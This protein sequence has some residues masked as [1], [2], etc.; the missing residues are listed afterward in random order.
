M[1]KNPPPTGLRL[2]ACMASGMVLV[3][4][5]PPA[6]LHWLHW[7][8]FLPMFWAMQPGQLRKN[9]VLAYLG[10]VAG[11]FVIFWWLIETV[12][13]FSS[14]PWALGLLVLILHSVGFSVS[15]AAIGSARWLRKRLGA[16][17]I[18]ALPVLVVAAERVCP[19]LFPWYHGVVHFKS[20]WVFQLASVTGVMG[21]SWVVVLVN[22]ALAELMYRRQ[23]GRS[24]PW[25]ALGLVTAVVLGV[26]GFGAWRTAAIEAEL[27]QAKTLRV[28]ILQQ[29]VTME[30]RLVQRPIEALASWIRL[31]RKVEDDQPDLVI[32]PEGSVNFN[33]NS[34]TEAKALGGRSPRV[35]FED[36]TR[37]ANFDFMIGGGT[38][39]RNPDAFKGYTAHNSLYVY[40][41]SGTLA[42]RYDKMVPLPFGEYMPLSDTF[43]F[44]KGIVGGVGDFR[45]GERPTTFDGTLADGSAYTYTAPICYE[46]IL[47]HTM[48]ELFYG[49]RDTPVD[50]F[51]NITNDAWFGDT[52]SPHQHGMLVATMA[53]QLGRPIV[54]IAYTGISFVVE[55]HGK[56]TLETAPFTEVA[57]VT[58]VRMGKANT[59]YMAG[60]WVFPWL[61][62]IGAGGI[63]FWARRRQEKSA[64]GQSEKLG[65]EGV[66]PDAP[67]A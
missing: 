13:R 40:H 65:S 5:S 39:E 33:P 29:N 16:G 46:G 18:F 59:V 20:T 17:W 15:F 41:R 31:T 25:P 56:F 37:E 67:L 55:P 34:E 23:E 36:M 58:E 47:S 3:F 12:Q 66:T 64:T 28:G 48:R 30:E 1:I 9:M 44:L 38:Y 35:F 57:E 6:N 8:S 45:A 60:G 22:T 27:A 10:G 32:W 50:V 49:E 43:P 11:N 63:V 53:T 26:V 4:I 42:D 61:C 51:V 19:T 52:G 14:L 54:R 7:F 21:V 62:V 2:L 24:P